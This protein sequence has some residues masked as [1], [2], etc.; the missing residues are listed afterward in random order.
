MEKTFHHGGH[1]DTAK[2]KSVNHGG[3]GD[4]G[5]KQNLSLPF[6]VPSVISVVHLVFR[7]VAVNAV[8]KDSVFNVQGTPQ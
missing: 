2:V 4:H 6:S 5:E 3:H 1:G 8:V 7:R